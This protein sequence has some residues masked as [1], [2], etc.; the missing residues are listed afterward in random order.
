MDVGYQWLF[1]CEEG[2]HHIAVAHCNTEGEPVHWYIDV[3]EAWHVDENGFP[4]FD[5]LFLDVVAL[6][7][8]QVEIIDRDELEAALEA[9][10][11]SR[12]Q[13]ELAWREPEAVTAA[14]KNQSFNPVQ[15]TRHFMNMFGS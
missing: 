6:P 3:I 9:R 7:N 14:I 15:L 11:I 12:A 4:Y 5:D 10:A 1:I 8:G 2:A 13:Y